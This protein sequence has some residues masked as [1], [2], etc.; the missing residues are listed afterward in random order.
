[1]QGN[2]LVTIW[3]F[4][5]QEAH[6]WSF[7]I[8]YILG[9][10]RKLVKNNTIKVVTQLTEGAF[11]QLNDQTTKIFKIQDDTLVSGNGHSAPFTAG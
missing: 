7:E 1:M 8:Y 10:Q 11:I 6:L 2:S 9:Q 4:N 3:P 5:P